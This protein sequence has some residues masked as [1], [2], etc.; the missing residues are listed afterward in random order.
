[1]A[2]ELFNLNWRPKPTGP[3][4]KDLGPGKTAPRFTP[5]KIT[6]SQG[7]FSNL[8]QFL[9]ERPVKIPKSLKGAAFVDPGYGAGF[10]ENVREFFRPTP[11][12]ALRT[13]SRMTVQW[14]PWH[15][16]FW[17]NLRDAIVA[18]KLPPLKMS[19]PPVQVREI[20]SKNEGFERAQALSL[21]AHAL[22]AVLIV[23]PFIHQLTQ[24][25]V[26]V[27][28]STEVIDISPYL[29]QLPP[30]KAKAGGGGGGGERSPVPT[31]KGRLPKF[32]M[33]QLSPPALVRN[34]N[35]KLPVPPTVVVPPE[36]RVPNPAIPNYGDPL[37]AILSDSQGPG[38]GGGFGSG[39][40]GGVGSGDGPGVGPGWGGGIGGGAFKAGAGG[41]GYPACIYCPNPTYTEEARKAKY[42]GTVLL[43]AIITVDGKATNV[44]VIKGAGLGLDERA[45][46]A[47]RNWRFK[48]AVGPDGRPVN[49]WSDI[50]IN[51]RIY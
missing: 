43:R 50:E 3:K 11:A 10:W 22:L 25:P 6:I 40:G 34:P 35:P 39:S 29:M 21:T 20:W 30:G 16:V 4:V 12:A 15:Q 28:A 44:R 18:P 9:F 45:I 38:S 1:M 26:A 47:V 32:S 33:T 51:F 5:D 13:Q 49:A 27:K 42:Q 8:K 46:E 17:E 7:F 36:I 23:V 19:S 41:V 2:D 24:E 37:A 31:T 14:K 48:A